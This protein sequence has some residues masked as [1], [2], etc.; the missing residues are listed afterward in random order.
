MWNPDFK[1]YISSQTKVAQG[2]VLIV[3]I[4]TSFSLSY[5][6]TQKD[7]KTITFE[8]TGGEYGNLFSF[9][10]DIKTGVDNNLKGDEKYSLQS[11]MVVRIAS[12]E[13]NENV[14]IEGSREITIDS[15]KESITL[16]GYI[17]IKDINQHRQ[18]PFSKIADSR[19]VFQTFLYPQEYVLTEADLEEIMQDLTLET[20]G[21]TAEET[22]LAEETTEAPVVEAA[23]SE[24][25]VKQIRISKEKKMELFLK[26][27][28]RMIDLL[29][30]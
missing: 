24:S 13:N 29:F 30:Q 25:A 2:D 6:S 20:E 3:L 23:S 26:Y 5:V 16:S 1:G 21:V 17:N 12:L 27:V 14:Y 7:S 9:L 4:D 28:N 19:L 8:Y 18:I 15:K 10:P 22:P 11:E